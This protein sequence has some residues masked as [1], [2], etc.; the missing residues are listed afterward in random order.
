M[1]PFN[2]MSSA[3]LIMVMKGLQ[4]IECLDNQSNSGDVSHTRWALQMMYGQVSNI[5]GTS[6][7]NKIVDHSDVVGAS[8]VSDAPTT[9]YFNFTPGLNIL[10]K[11]NYKTRWETFKFWDFEWLIL[12]VWQ[13][14]PINVLDVMLHIKSWYISYL[15]TYHVYLIW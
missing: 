13:Y 12:E 2:R 4:V 15:V 5:G 10:H 14:M 6:V 9:S 11:D 7:G 1:L 8:P 3:N